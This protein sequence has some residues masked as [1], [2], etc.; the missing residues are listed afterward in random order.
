MS[1]FLFP[2]QQR[3]Y[4]C[5]AL[6]GTI[7]QRKNCIGVQKTIR[8]ELKI[9][10]VSD[11]KVGADSAIGRVD[12]VSKETSTGLQTEM[13]AEEGTSA[14]ANEA[15]ADTANSSAMVRLT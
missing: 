9:A 15:S 14:S 7:E 4:F 13:A 1:A 3:L 2:K 6:R 11:L 12:S 8:F 5:K 10:A